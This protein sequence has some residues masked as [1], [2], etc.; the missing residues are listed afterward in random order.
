MH[1]QNKDVVAL[2]LSTIDNWETCC[3]TEYDKEGT[4]HCGLNIITS[5]QE[6]LKFA[7]ENKINIIFESMLNNKVGSPEGEG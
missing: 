5:V 4:W 2:V 3:V 1:L 7:E 6:A